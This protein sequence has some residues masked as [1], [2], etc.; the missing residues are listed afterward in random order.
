MQ[1]KIQLNNVTDVSSCQWAKIRA[2]TNYI[3]WDLIHVFGT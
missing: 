1:Q 2:S 3:L